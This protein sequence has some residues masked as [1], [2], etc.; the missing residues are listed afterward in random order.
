MVKQ[1]S[2]TQYPRRGLPVRDFIRQIKSKRPPD[3]GKL[4]SQLNRAGIYYTTKHGNYKQGNKHF[5]ALVKVGAA[6]LKEPA[7]GKAEDP[8]Y[9]AKKGTATLGHNRIPG[10]MNMYAGHQ[11]LNTHRLLG[12]RT[13]YGDDAF[14]GGRVKGGKQGSIDPNDPGGKNRYINS[15]EKATKSE[16]AKQANADGNDGLAVAKGAYT[17]KMDKD[18]G[19]TS[20]R[21]LA[22]GD[23]SAEWFL[24][25][26]DERNKQGA[27]PHQQIMQ[28]M[29][30]HQVPEHSNKEGRK[31]HLIDPSKRL[32]V[33]SDMFTLGQGGGKHLTWPQPG[34]A[35]AARLA[36]PYVQRGNAQ[37]GVTSQYQTQNLKGRKGVQA[38][39]HKIRKLVAALEKE[40]GKLWRMRQVKG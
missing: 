36:Q 20:Q 3:E 31:A 24:V 19:G 39:A 18:G 23:G 26:W 5:D 28:A 14:N 33:Y 30:R 27:T 13:L 2:L 37:D 29:M 25:N 12:A 10:R 16:L 6:G 40:R 38:Q 9:D 21:Q 4:A 11:G 17:Y 8:A 35:Q 1:V 22:K 7:S 32:D 15:M 34:T